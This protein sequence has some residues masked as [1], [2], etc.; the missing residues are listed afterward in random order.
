MSKKDVDINQLKTV[1]RQVRQDILTMLYEAGSGHTGGSLSIVEIL[2][3]LYYVK[4]HTRPENPDWGERDRFILSKGHGAPALY[5]ILARR[6]YFNH[7]ELKKLRKINSMLQG[8]PYNRS[9]PGVEISTG[10]LGQGLS[11]ANGMALAARLDNKPFWVY[12]LVGDGEIQEGQIW[13]AAMSAAHFK[14]NNLCCIVDYNKLQIDGPLSEIKGVEPLQ[15]KWQA[16][17]WRVKEVD[18]HDFSQLLEAF[19]WAKEKSGEPSVII[20]HTVKGK[21][22]SFMENKVAY[23][24]VAPTK[25]ELEKALSEI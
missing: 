25:E 21:A 11:V 17:G 5:S 8:H 14:L 24:G 3:S 4:M 22:V 13:E 2:V 23:H 1:A 9:T 6:G 7:S 16:F 19:E 12:V 15:D 10:S 20:A 18:G